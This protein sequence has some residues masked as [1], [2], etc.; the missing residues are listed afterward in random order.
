MHAPAAEPPIRKPPQAITSWRPEVPAW[1]ISTLLHLSV[2]TVLGLTLRL[3]PPLA[4]GTER[5]AEVG[6]VLKHQD[7]EKDYYVGEQDGGSQS[8]APAAPATTSLAEALRASPLDPSAV[9]PNIP[10]VIG[11]GLPEGGGVPSAG[12]AADGPGAGR[13]LDGG[14]GRTRFINIEA[15][16]YKFAYVL[17]R[18]ASM[19]GAGR[20]PL[21]FAKSELI[22]SLQSLGKTHQFL[23]VF[24]NEQPTVFNPSGQQAKLAFATEQNKQRA[25]KFI[26]SITAAGGTRH[27]EALVAAIK[28]QPDVIFFLTDADE[29]RLSPRQL[30]KI[31]RMAGG[32]SINTIEFGFGPKSGPASFLAELARQND[33]KYVYVDITRLGRART[34]QP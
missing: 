18:S 17:D 32:I 33:G 8:P 34:G 24:Y 31:H 23:I 26:G 7:G 29:P 21:A 28:T 3:A 22:A 6:I 5:T 16:G 4:A 30:D 9:L 19:D 1:L 14:K 12:K 13:E 25:R 10:S 20:S 2:L 27:E 11:P 15:E